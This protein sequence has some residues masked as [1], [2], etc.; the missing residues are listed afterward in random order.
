MAAKPLRVAFIK[1]AGLFT[2]G[3]ERWLQMMAASLPKDRYQ[4]DYYAS[5]DLADP[6]RQAYLEENGVRVIRFEVKN[7]DLAT[8]DWEWKD[9]N[10][11]SV[12]NEDNY[13]FIQANK[14]RGPEY[15]FNRMKKIPVVEYRTLT[16]IPDHSANIVFSI[17]P[18]HWQRDHWWKMGGL[19][20]KSSVIFIP[21]LTPATDQ[22]WRT[23]LGI[24]ADAVVAGSHQRVND[25]IFSPIPLQA[26]AR[27]Q[28]P[29]RF[30]LIMGGSPRYGEQARRLGLK[31]FCQLPHNS[32]LSA[33][34]SFLNTLD[35]F[36]HGR[37]DG[38]AFGMALA[39][40][41]MHGK[42]CMSHRTP[43]ANAQGETMG[44]AG[45]FTANLTEYTQT[46]SRFY[47]DAAFR[48][49]Y[50]VNARPHAERY[51][52]LEAAVQHLDDIYTRLF[53]P[54]SASHF[55]C[56]AYRETGAGFLCTY[57][58]IDANP[59]SRLTDRFAIY[60]SLETFRFV[61]QAKGAEEM[62]YTGTGT[63]WLPW[64]TLHH[65]PHL[66]GRFIAVNEKAY[67]L[68]KEM[69]TLNRWETRVTV[70]QLSSASRGMALLPQPGGVFL[71]AIRF[72]AGWIV[73]A[74]CPILYWTAKSIR[75]PLRAIRARGKRF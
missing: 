10:F 46:L 18:S 71:P 35:V 26:F 73:R 52:S 75:H 57:P 23:K 30:Y 65:A 56:S 19:E 14:S 25:D 61:Q 8:P 39:E 70:E 50:A 1:H 34:S 41:L 4:V 7:R 29:G 24:P 12:F 51:F 42:P 11:W 2:G 59:L 32:D 9:T 20:S 21:A 33:V 5:D 64:L 54:A 15:P 36:T 31:G 62:T 43:V 60:E 69:L 63:D 66:R 72:A 67:A 44:P 48:Q 45:I 47:S 49:S 6:K 16:G 27:L 37:A 55:Q 22:H 28:A 40:A 58:I 17:H 68:M 53:R 13:D 3:T 74:A 38:E